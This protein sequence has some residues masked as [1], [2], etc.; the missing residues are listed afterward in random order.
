MRCETACKVELKVAGGGRRAITRTLTVK[1]AKA[2]KVPAR[3]GRLHVRVAVDG[4]ELASGKSVA[5]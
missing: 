5:R 2:L 4:K 1:G 3:H